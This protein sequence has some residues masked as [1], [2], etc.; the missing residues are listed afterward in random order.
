MWEEL[1]YLTVFY[2]TEGTRI[3]LR[4][5]IRRNYQVKRTGLWDTHTDTYALR[6]IVYLYTYCKLIKDDI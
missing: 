3:K 2:L 5:G 6:V 1:K 4:E